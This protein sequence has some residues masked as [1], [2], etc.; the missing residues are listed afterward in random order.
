MLLK[1]TLQDGLSWLVFHPDK[2]EMKFKLTRVC[3]KKTDLEIGEG[4]DSGNLRNQAVIFLA[5][6]KEECIRL[7]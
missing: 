2:N 6:Y 1:T 3:S 7:N 5:K 4:A